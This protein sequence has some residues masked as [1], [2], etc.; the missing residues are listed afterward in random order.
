MRGFRIATTPA[1]AFSRGCVS[2][3]RTLFCAFA[4][5]LATRSQHRLESCGAAAKGRGG[6][7]SAVHAALACVAVLLA[8]GGGTMGVARAL[9][10]GAASRGT[11]K[12]AWF[13]CCVQHDAPTGARGGNRRSPGFKV[14]SMRAQR[15]EAARGAV[16]SGEPSAR[17]CC[18]NGSGG[19]GVRLCPAQIHDYPFKN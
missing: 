4:A 15:C 11:C 14:L 12:R 17:I 13:S 5:V 6:A 16:V 8:E 10:T 19:R 2:L 3:Y 9:R 7:A 1:R 18:S